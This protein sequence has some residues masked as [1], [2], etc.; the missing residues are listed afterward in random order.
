MLPIIQVLVQ[1]INII[2]IK[3][4]TRAFCRNFK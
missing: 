2:E 3:K 4:K 1:H